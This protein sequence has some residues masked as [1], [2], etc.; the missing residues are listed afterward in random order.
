[1]RYEKS[2]KRDTREAQVDVNEDLSLCRNCDRITEVVIQQAAP[3]AEAST[4]KVRLP[5][6]QRVVM[7]EA[8]YRWMI[9]IIATATLVA[10]CLQV[11]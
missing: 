8:K 7:C 2:I 6:W 4:P 9:L 1:M 11:G 10:T 5:W 3:Q